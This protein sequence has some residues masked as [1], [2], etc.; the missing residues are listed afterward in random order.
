MEHRTSTQAKSHH[1]KMIK[2]Y[3]NVSNIIKELG[4]IEPKMERQSTSGVREEV[5]R[6]EKHGEPIE[7]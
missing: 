6:E 1:Q 7:G 5:A 3:H 4:G 2:K